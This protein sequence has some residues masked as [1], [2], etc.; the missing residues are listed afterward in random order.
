V[1]SLL[2]NMMTKWKSERK[3][4]SGGSFISDVNRWFFCLGCESVFLPGV[5]SLPVP[6]IAHIDL[7]ASFLIGATDRGKMAQLKV[8]HVLS[9]PARKSC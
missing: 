5:H 9:F 2:D 6:F 3:G 7:A 1:H 4:D 8:A